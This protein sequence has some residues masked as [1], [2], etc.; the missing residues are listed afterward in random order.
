[1]DAVIEWLPRVGAIL[2]LLIGLVGFFKPQAFADNMGI[3][4]NKPEAWSE[5]RTVMG[6]LNVGGALGALIFQAPEVFMT[7][8]LAWL[9]GL[10][11]RFWSI[12]KDDMTIKT[13]IPAFIVDGGLAFLFLSPLLL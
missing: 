13:S 9:F 6:G 7:L 10:F 3:G 8:G 12:L 4:L 5:L 11:A 1:M 2:M